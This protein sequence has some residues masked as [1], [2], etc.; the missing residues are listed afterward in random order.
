MQRAQ[1]KFVPLSEPHLNLIL[2]WLKESHI[3]KFW[4]EAENEDEVRAKYRGKAAKNIHGYMI[5][6][7]GRLVGYIQHY[8][9]WNVG[10]G[11]WPDAKPGTYG[12]DVMLGD[13][14]LVGKG[15]GTA[16]I[17][18]FLA[19]LLALMRA[20]GEKAV[21][22]VIADPDPAN[23]GAIRAFEKVGFKQ[24]G[25]VPTP[26]GDSLLMTLRWETVAG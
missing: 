9:A 12:L 6:L 24:V 19:D 21:R 11:W 20:T 22:E 26:Y 8:E 17:R 25:M 2:S 15:I 23:L 14:A 3:R 13:P 5:E 1:F 4:S 7:D 18:E 10:P 16:A